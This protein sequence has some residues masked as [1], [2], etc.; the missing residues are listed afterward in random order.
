V[1][2]FSF[3]ESDLGINVR[4]TGEEHAKL[5]KELGAYFA[6]RGF[7]NKNVIGR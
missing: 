3:N 6:T 7:A 5:I 4:Q 1:K 2:L